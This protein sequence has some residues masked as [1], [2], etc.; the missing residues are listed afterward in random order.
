MAKKLPAPAATPS[1]AGHLL[2][3]DGL[4]GYAALNVAFTHAW[5]VTYRRL[6]QDPIPYWFWNI[7][8]LFIPGEWSVCVFI[9]LSGYCLAL[10]ISKSA[11][12]RLTGGVMRYFGRRAR[13]ILPAYYAA[14]VL[15]LTMIAALP[16][17]TSA[18][19]SPGRIL[20]PAFESGVFLS[21]LF[22]VHNLSPAWIVKILSPAWSIAIEWQIYF[23]LPLVFLPIWRLIGIF[24]VLGVGLLLGLIAPLLLHDLGGY[25]YDFGWRFVAMFSFGIASAGFCYSKYG[26][27][28]V[29]LKESLW[30][31]AAIALAVSCIASQFTPMRGQKAQ[32]FLVGLAASALII[33]CTVD[34]NAGVTSAVLRFLSARWSRLLGSFSYSLYLIHSIVYFPCEALFYYVGLP[35]FGRYLLMLLVAL[36]LALVISYLFYLA[37]ERPIMRLS[38]KSSGQS[39]GGW[40][41]GKGGSQK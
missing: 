25:N 36:P 12:L 1:E 21:H 35:L 17:V 15:S 8:H 14:L 4:R 11:D 38:I 18:P 9:V 31:G 24:G 34:S 29:F 41:I 19:N 23:L 30:R 37:V 26:V 3:L 27:K 28:S 20:V 40:D 5:G 7:R 10:P 6:G 33:S 2:F 13:R 22:L 16:A 32:D 39:L